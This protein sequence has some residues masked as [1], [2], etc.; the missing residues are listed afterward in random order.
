MSNSTLK[1]RLGGSECF[2]ARCWMLD[3][4]CWLKTG[5][6]VVWRG[7]GPGGWSWGVWYLVGGVQG[8]CWVWGAL[9]VLG[10]VGVG[11]G[12]WFCG[13][14]FLWGAGVAQ[15]WGGG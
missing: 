6:A 8:G 13:V 15:P 7:G 14:F 12:V 10:S 11:G 1:G 2:R 9:L 3:F 4:G 5:A